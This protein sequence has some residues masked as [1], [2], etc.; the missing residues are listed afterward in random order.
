MIHMLNH[1]SP[2]KGQTSM[3]RG[4]FRN[5]YVHIDGEGQ[6]MTSRS[7]VIIGKQEQALR[8]EPLV[9]HGMVRGGRSVPSVFRASTN[10]PLTCI[11]WSCRAGLCA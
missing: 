1:T 5:R 11:I 10:N 6:V 3:K 7:P 2:F 9:Q 4:I 8:T